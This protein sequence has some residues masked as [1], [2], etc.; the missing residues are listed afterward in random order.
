MQLDSPLPDVQLSALACLANMCYKNYGVCVMVASA[1]TS[2]SMQGRLVP[3]ALGQLM[4]REKSCLIQLEAARCV[5]YMHRTGV[6]VHKDPRIIYRALPCLVRLCRRD[7]LPRE[8]VA[9][10]ETLAFLTEVN[11]EL[12]RLASISNHLIP[13]LA[14]FLRPH[15]HVSPIYY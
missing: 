10:A 14:E 4:G 8:R 7:R 1:T 6:L 3:V 13:T 12:Q 2:N 11:T 15:L 5:T 9:A